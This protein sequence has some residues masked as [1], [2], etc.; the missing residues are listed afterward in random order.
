[1]EIGYLLGGE[2]E[3]TLAGPACTKPVDVSL[4]ER[5][6]REIT[7]YRRLAESN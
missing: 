1:L 7:D 3:R 2:V 4:I 6:R 5:Q